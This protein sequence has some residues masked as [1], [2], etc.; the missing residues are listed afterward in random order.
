[1]EFNDQNPS[2]AHDEVFYSMTASADMNWDQYWP[3]HPGS[4]ALYHP[5]MNG[6]VPGHWTHYVDHSQSGSHSSPP[7]AQYLSQVWDPPGQ[8]QA[9]CQYVG[10]GIDDQVTTVT[11]GSRRL[12]RTTLAHNLTP[13][14]SQIQDLMLLRL[15]RSIHK[16]RSKKTLLLIPNLRRLLVLVRGADTW[17]GLQFDAGT[18]VAMAENSPRSATTDG[19]N[20]NVRV[21]LQCAFVHG[22]VPLSTDVGPGTIMWS[23]VAA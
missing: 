19:T 8:G 1:M 16:A 13:A 22:V 17:S 5:Q 11:Q 9:D 23:E 10:G 2:A 6:H 15:H 4:S 3:S 21:K 12:F 20:E 7:P 18:M 14:V